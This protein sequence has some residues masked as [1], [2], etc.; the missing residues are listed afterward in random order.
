MR[1]LFLT[2]AIIFTILGIIFTFLPL[3]TLALLPIGVALIFS[4]L[5]FLKSDETNKK[6]TKILIAIALIA[7]LAVF[8]KQYLTT[9]E[10]APDAVF[11][12]AKVDTKAEAKKDLEDL[13]K[14]LP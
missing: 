1:K 5:A 6:I 12:K 2:L 3:G 14:D 13:E 11:D 9:D 10:V 8:G 4:I 7:G